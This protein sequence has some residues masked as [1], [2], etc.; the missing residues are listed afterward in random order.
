MTATGP[1]QTAPPRAD[2]ADRW[3]VD[4][5]ALRQEVRSKYRA[6]AL[7]PD[8][9]HHFHT[10]RALARHLGYA[11]ETVAGLPDA[12]VESFAGVGNPFSLRRVGAGERVVDVGSGAGFDTFVAAAAVGADGA[13]VGVD[14][15]A[16]ML[17]KARATAAGL[18]FGHVAFR[19]GLAESLPVPDARPRGG[20]P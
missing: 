11:D 8:G 10:G 3:I 16:E 1:S 15:T 2:G 7:E 19:E 14:M 20:G 6:V 12:A 18:G 17:T 9:E 13:V 5:Q 4:P